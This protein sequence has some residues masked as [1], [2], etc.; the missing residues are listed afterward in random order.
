MQY[1]CFLVAIAVNKLYAII[2]ARNARTGQP[3]G[4]RELLLPQTSVAAGRQVC[5][6]DCV[7]HRCICCSKLWTYYLGASF[8]VLLLL[9]HGNNALLTGQYTTPKTLTTPTSHTTSSQQWNIIEHA[10][11]SSRGVHDKSSTS[12]F[13]PN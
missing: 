12:A 2:S 1:V 10:C 6:R 9:V 7:H 4:G 5:R 3:D 8:V 13:L 11:T